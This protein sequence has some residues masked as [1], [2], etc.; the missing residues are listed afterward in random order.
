MPTAL[1]FTSLQTDMQAYLERGSIQDATVYAQLPRLINLAERGIVRDTKIQGFITVLTTTLP[2]N[3][4]TL[5]KPDGWRETVS[6]YY[7]AGTSRTPIFPRSYDYCRAYW[8]DPAVTGTVQFY[9]D[10]DY[11][12]W[13]FVA[14]P[15]ALLNLEILCYMQP[16]LLDSGNTTNWLTEYA[17]EVLEYR[18]FWE[19]ALF[20]KDDAGAGRWAQKYQAALGGV[21][22][23]DLQK[24]IDRS[25]TRIEA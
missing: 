18:A 19:M 15:A 22:T 2:A 20:L 24:I 12:N 11:Q 1:T 3:T 5:A 8:P 14:T 6:M 23:E 16:P 10:Y 21:N 7:G 4:S 9:A 25:V 13:L 17:P